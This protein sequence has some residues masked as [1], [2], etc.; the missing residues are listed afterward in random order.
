MVS[1]VN[2]Q[3]ILSDNNLQSDMFQSETIGRALIIEKELQRG[4]SE[5]N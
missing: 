1:L 4:E 5:V 3:T 2:C